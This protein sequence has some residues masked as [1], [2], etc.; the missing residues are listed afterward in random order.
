M[1]TSVT[2]LPESR[3][4]IDVAVEPDALAK[5]I[6]RAA[7]Q[8]AGEMKLPGFR[9]GK[10]PAQLVIQ[11]VGREAVVEQALRDSLPEWYEQALLDSGVVTVGDP[12]LDVGDLPDEGQELEFTIEVGVRPTAELGEWRG[13][14]VGQR[15][16]RGPRRCGRRR[17][18]PPAGGLREPRPGRPPRR[19]RRQPGPRHLGDDRRGAVRGLR[20]PATT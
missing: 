9:K 18:R 10:V 3:V 11:R 7:K 5:R 2:D 14:E 12:K 20:Q 6:D 1:R 19:A 15:R 17:A 8:L 13:L 16:R 4:K